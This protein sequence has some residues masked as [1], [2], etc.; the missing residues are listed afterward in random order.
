VTVTNADNSSDMLDNAFTYIAG[1]IG[2]ADGNCTAENAE[3][4]VD[5][6]D[7][8][9]VAKHAVGLD[10]T[11]INLAVSNVDCN[12]EVNTYDA[13]KIAEYDAQIV[14]SLPDCN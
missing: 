4:C 13:L 8:L 7:A 5:I 10:A 1:V 6:F 11:G 2:D 9:L 14:T 3:W 12:T